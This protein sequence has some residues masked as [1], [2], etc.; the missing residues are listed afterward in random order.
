MVSPR[1]GSRATAAPSATA[2]TRR[3]S[4]DWRGLSDRVVG[5]SAV[6]ESSMSRGEATAMNQEQDC[7]SAVCPRTNS[8]SRRFCE[9]F[10]LNNKAVNEQLSRAA[11][12]DAQNINNA[13]RNMRVAHSFMTGLNVPPPCARAFYARG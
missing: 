5:R 11:C 9:Y 12:G 1:S 4:A 3:R 2:S 13:A 10:L 7:L 8:R 6:D